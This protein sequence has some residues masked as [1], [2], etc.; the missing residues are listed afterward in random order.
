MCPNLFIN[1]KRGLMYL[2]LSICMKTN[3]Y[4]WKV[5]I[6]KTNMEMDVSQLEF[7]KIG[8]SEEQAA[9]ISDIFLGQ[10]EYMGSFQ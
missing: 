2:K 8:V 6:I 5:W 7:K 4:I 9:L 10:T 1:K 3:S